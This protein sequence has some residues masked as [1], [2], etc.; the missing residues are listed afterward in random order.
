MSTCRMTR[1]RGTPGLRAA[2]ASGLVSGVEVVDRADPLA[3]AG[4]RLQGGGQVLLGAG[5]R[6]ERGQAVRQVGGDGGREGAAGAVGGARLHALGPELLE[7][8]PVEVEV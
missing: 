8:L 7:G 3:E 6:F 4:I 5:D 1:G 2:G